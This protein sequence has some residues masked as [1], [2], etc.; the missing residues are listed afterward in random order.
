[1]SKKSFH[2]FSATTIFI[3]GL[4]VA[5]AQGPPQ[6][7]RIGILIPESGRPETQSVK[8]LREGLKE[9]GYKERENILV[10]MRDGKGDRAALKPMANELVDKKVDLIFTTG[11][12]ATEVAI[13]ATNKIPI[14]FRYR[15]N[16]QTVGLVKSNARPGGNVTG[17]AGFG[18]ETTGKRLETLQQIVPGVRRV[19]IFYDLN[20]KFSRGNF[21][22][23]KESAEKLGLKVLEHGTKSAEELK[24][25]FDNLEKTPG[26]ALFHV[27]D[28]LVEGEVDFIF[29]SARQKKLPTMFDEEA[30][31]IRGALGAYGPSHYQMG[32]QAAGFA[33]KILKGQKPENLPVEP[34]SKYD[35]V[36]NFRTA[37]AIGLTIP[38]D[39]LK[40]ADRVIR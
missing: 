18:L 1:M 20:D 24:T 27:P 16:P 32:R 10:E 11:T 5:E 9:L 31:V 15:G 19:H 39:V 2:F 28:N 36:I 7:P 29:R 6:I 17:V 22:V 3:L 14:I 37:N 26:D 21:A 34:A 40:K 33:D 13:A 35:L 8:G 38:P 23:A 30:W 12:R 4:S 25:S